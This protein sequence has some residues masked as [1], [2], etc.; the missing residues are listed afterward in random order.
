[1]KRA[2]KRVLVGVLA[3]A[4]ATPNVVAGQ[5]EIRA[6]D[7]T[8][9]IGGRVQVQTLTSSVDGA[10]SIETKMRRGRI[11]AGV[12][13]GDL[14][15]ARIQ[16]DFTGSNMQLQ[17]AV[18]ALHFAPGFVLSMGQMKRPSELFEMSTSTRLGIIERD[19][20]VP[21]AG[22]CS[23]V[24]GLC[25]FSRLTEKLSFSG[26]DT[27][28]QVSGT[29]GR[30]SYAAMVM[31]GTGINKSDENGAESF[32]AR[33]S[34]DVGSGVALGGFV[35]SHDYLDPGGNTDRATAY[36]V[37]LDW[38]EWAEGVHFQV[39][40]VAGDNWKELDIG[41]DPANFM[42]AMAVITY[43]VPIESDQWAGIEPLGRI[44]WSDPD[45]DVADDGGWLLTPGLSFIISGRNKIATNL[46]IYAP[47]TGSTELSFKLQAFVYY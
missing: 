34:I 26:R 27:G 23:G 8:I 13:V 41:G 4:A 15:Q 30:F 12:T 39:A 31:N 37:D 29:A 20:R 11:F 42:T 24:G 6:R 21:G 19:G 2:V 1:M 40:W 16:P 3:I 7:A 36:G 14:L 46:D 18:V 9:T 45:R 28:L 5:T 32:S 47:E 10:N 35:G 33:T 38:G 43:F 17:D 44:S 25:T 22:D